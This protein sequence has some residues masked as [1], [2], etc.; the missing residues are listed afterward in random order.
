MTAF[1][2]SDV[3][4][5]KNYNS[6]QDTCLWF[7]FLFFWQVYF[8]THSALT[9]SA[10]FSFLL[11]FENWHYFQTYYLPR[12]LEALHL[13]PFCRQLLAQLRLSTVLNSNNNIAV[14]SS[15][16]CNTRRFLILLL[17]PLTCN[18]AKTFS[19]LFCNV[20]IFPKICHNTFSCKGSI[21][22]FVFRH[23]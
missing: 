21:S 22:N 7:F 13:P 23:F 4:Q 5:Q 6:L 19:I 9:L 14:I 16:S 8:H 20:C 2:L 12:L 15:I 11:L 17:H 18:W 10:E 1:P 3:L